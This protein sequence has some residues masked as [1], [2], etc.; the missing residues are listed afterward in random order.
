MAADQ[1]YMGT[2]RTSSGDVVKVYMPLMKEFAVL[3]D[4]FHT[5]GELPTS[6]AFYMELA[7]M[8]CRQPIAFIEEMGIPD[9]MR[10]IRMIISAVLLDMPAEAEKDSE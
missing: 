9:G 2:F 8:A 7:A 10:L 5:G 1:E 3:V 6:Y 4:S